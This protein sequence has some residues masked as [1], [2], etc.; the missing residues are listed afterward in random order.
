MLEDYLNIFYNWNTYMNI[1]SHVILYEIIHKLLFHIKKLLLG[2]INLTILF[3]LSNFFH[4]TV[5]F[6]RLSYFNMSSKI[7]FVDIVKT[8]L[9]CRM[10]S[11]VHCSQITYMCINHPKCLMC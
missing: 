10:I 9:E 2:K 6:I 1:E 7:I 5:C 8:N 3:Y 4:V 11:M